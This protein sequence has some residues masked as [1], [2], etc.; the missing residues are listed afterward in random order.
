MTSLS[1]RYTKYACTKGLEI[2]RNQIYYK[3]QLTADIDF[4]YVNVDFVAYN[5]LD[6]NLPAVVMGWGSTFV[7]L[8]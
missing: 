2:G 3:F 6:N 5:E 1:L 8:H 7:S 4:D